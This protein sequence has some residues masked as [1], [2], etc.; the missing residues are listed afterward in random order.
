MITTSNGTELEVNAVSPVALRNLLFGSGAFR[1]MAHLASKSTTEVVAQI[2]QTLT[3]DEM[4]RLSAENTRLYNFICAYGV[5]TDPPE[6]ALEQL[7]AMGFAVESPA[8]ARMHWLQ[9]LVLT[10]DDSKILLNEV[11]RLTFSATG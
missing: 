5:S 4:L 8:I 11:I 6:D 9:M 10:D 7:Q 2:Q 1:K 3:Q